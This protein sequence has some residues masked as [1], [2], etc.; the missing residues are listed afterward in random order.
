[1]HCPS[2][3]TYDLISVRSTAFANDGGTGFA[4]TKFSAVCPLPG[5]RLRITHDNLAVAK[6]VRD[7]SEGDE[8]QDHFV[9]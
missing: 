4:E 9:A 2:E 6:F 1:M 5:C 8:A 3:V 7:L